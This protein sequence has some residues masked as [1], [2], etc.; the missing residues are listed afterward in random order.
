MR[1]PT[2]YIHLEGLVTA[3][4]DKGGFQ[5]PNSYQVALEITYNFVV[6]A[7]HRAEAHDGV[8]DGCVFDVSAEG[9]DGVLTDA[10][11]HTGRW[12]VAWRRENRATVRVEELKLRGVVR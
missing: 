9:N 4:H 11:V 10:A 8:D 5:V 1:T 2:S 7:Y 3:G 6:R 12:Q